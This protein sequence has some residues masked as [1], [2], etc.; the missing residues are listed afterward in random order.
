[1]NAP[2]AT[3]WMPELC[4]LPRL[5]AMCGLALLVVVVLA[6]APDGSRHWSMARLVS[7]S[8]FALWLA[9]AVSGALCVLRRVLSRLPPVAGSLAAIGLTAVIAV[10]GA[11]IIHAL[12]AVLGDSFTRGIGF[13]RFTLGSAATTALI[14]AVALRYF[15]VSDRWAAQVQAKARAEA[16]A[17]QARIRPHFLFNS[18]NLIASLVRRDPVVAERAV[19]DLS[20]LFRAALGAGDGDSTLQGECELAERYLSIETLRL[21][22]RLQVRWQ[23]PDDLPWQHPMPRLVLQPLVENAVLHG[24]S[25][26]PEGGTI[27]LDIACAEGLLQILIRNPAP[28]P[29]AP[30]LALTQGAGHALHN[31]AH[32]LA[33]RFGAGARMTAGWSGGYYECRITI[34]V[35]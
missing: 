30:S 4:R 10:L 29:E 11:G 12:Y 26:L 3:P 34:P 21:G 19:L 16:D 14:S 32:R 33:W 20:D 28:D 9:L 27:E 6:L 15:Y 18:M 7:A 25:R 5:A 23:R 22:D 31:I 8:G 13:W 1:M 2:A 35:R 17:L 24:I